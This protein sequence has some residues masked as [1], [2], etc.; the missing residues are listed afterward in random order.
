M[1]DNIMANTRKSRVPKEEQLKLIN[2]CRTSGM[3]D[4]D[5]CREHGIAVSTFYYW[6]KRL[7]KKAAQIPAPAYG[8]SENPRPKQD[9]VP[10]D[11][12]PERFPVQHTPYLD[13]PHTLEIILGSATIHVT[14]ET[15][16]QLLSRTLQIL[17][18]SLSM[19]SEQTELIRSLRTIIEEKTAHEMVLQE[20]VD[21]LTKKLFGTSSEKTLADIPG[22]LNLFNEAEAEQDPEL[23]EEDCSQEPRPRKKKATHAELFK[24]LKVHKEVIPLNEEDKVCPVCGTPMERIGEEYVRRELV[25]T[26]AICEVYEYYTES[27]GCPD[28]KEGKG[29][30]EKSVIVKSKVPPALIGKGPA[31][32]STVAW[33]IYQKYANGMP[34]YRQEKDWKE[35]GAAVSRTTLANWIIY[36]AEHYFRPLYDYFHRQ[37][38]LREFLMA[39]ETRVQVLKE[40]GRSA[41]SQS[42]MWLYRTGEDGLPVILLYGY[43]PT[44]SGDNAADFLDGFQGYLETD[45]YQG[46]NKV[47]GIKRCSCWAHIRRYFVDAIPKGKQLDYNQP[48]V[49]GV[50]Y[51]DRLARLES[52]ISGK[53]GA[54]YEKRKQMRLEKEKP[55]LEA[56]WAWVDSQKPVRNTRLDKALT[57]VKNRRETSMTYL[58]DG[59]C[60]FTNNLSENAIRPFTVGRKNWLFSDSVEGAEASAIAY[61][62]V[63]M[64]KAHNLNIYQYLSYVLEQ[65]PNE[66]WSDEQL[67][68][69]APWSEKLQTLKM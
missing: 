29:D 12:V 65:R 33:T 63:E 45:G 23:P 18:G 19:M 9:V 11:I 50:H 25:F 47:S 56:F 13:N 21:Y 36:S 4:I 30:T 55:V 32:S 31:S 38:L 43:T 6:V 35:Y 40:P 15:D 22:Q 7:R 69:L 3:T 67:A 60:S 28:C 34:L 24:G 48:A 68:E 42:F 41:E 37:L 5:W 52:S 16:P 17:K 10:I 62:M 66:N 58:E 46:Y 53:C 54:D 44:R 57:Y 59:R 8:H 27:Y 51:C 26:P 39:D 20:Q 49:Q 64:A 2:E 1:E 61:T 14:N